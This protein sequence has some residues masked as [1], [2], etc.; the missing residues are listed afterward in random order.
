ME[1]YV[2]IFYVKKYIK[3]YKLENLLKDEN[4]EIYTYIRKKDELSIRLINENILIYFYY[5]ALT[6]I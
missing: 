3:I 5:F 6:F 4:I 2:Y 1:I